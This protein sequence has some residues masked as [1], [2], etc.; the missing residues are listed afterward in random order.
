MAW[1]QEW[2]FGVVISLEVPSTGTD[3]PAR[4]RAVARATPDGDSDRRSMP[5]S[6]VHPTSG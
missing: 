6:A 2:P 1:M 4:S 5:H 3:D